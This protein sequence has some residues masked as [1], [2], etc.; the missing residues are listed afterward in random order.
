MSYYE[1]KLVDASGYEITSS[2]RETLKAAKEHARYLISDR[3]AYAVNG[4]HADWGTEKAEVLKNGID[5]VWD[6]SHPQAR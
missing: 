5:C 6:I 2:E 4:N 1:I 3:Y